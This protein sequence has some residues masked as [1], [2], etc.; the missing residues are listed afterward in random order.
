MLEEWKSVV[1]FP[2]RVSFFR[3]RARG[4]LLAA[5][6]IFCLPALKQE[7]C[8]S[9]ISCVSLSVYHHHH[10]HYLSHLSRLF[11]T[12]SLCNNS[13]FK[14]TRSNASWWIIKQ[15]GAILHFT[16]PQVKTFVSYL[17]L[18]FHQ[19]YSK[20]SQEPWIVNK[21]LLFT[22]ELVHTDWTLNLY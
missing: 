13:I 3:H 15:K 19:T 22:V 1:V 11:P 20:D 8:P 17:A 6:L 9:P 10:P 7:G 21:C 12:A 16:L 14:R 18:D 5:G 4:G 2:R